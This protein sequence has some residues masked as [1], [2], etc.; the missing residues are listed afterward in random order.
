MKK[1]FC[2]LILAFFAMSVTGCNVNFDKLIYDNMSDLRIN[3]FSGEN[4][5]FSADLSCGYREEV[6]AYDGISTNKKECGVL[7]LEFKTEYSYK[8]V[9]VCVDINGNKK[10]YQLDKSPFENKYMA[11]LEKIITENDSIVLTLKNQTEQCKI[12]MTSLSWKIQYKDALKVA[13]NIFNNDFNNLYFNNKLNCECYLKVVAKPNY[14]QTFWYFSFIDRSQNS[15]SV[16]IDTTSG[17]VFEHNI[18]STK[19]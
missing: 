4:T 19:K 15:K 13:L 6:F 5:I 8:S 2:V 7:A 12:E 3:Y 18:E 16:L 17:K 9:C 1:L 11:D 10:D 14:S